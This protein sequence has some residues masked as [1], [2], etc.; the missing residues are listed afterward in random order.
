MLLSC[1]AALACGAFEPA[2][3][4][5]AQR[6][7]EHRIVVTVEK[8]TTSRAGSLDDFH[9]D[10]PWFEGSFAQA[11]ARA[12]TNGSGLLVDFWAEWCQPCRRMGAT[13]FRDERVI[14]DLCGLVCVSV[15]SQSAT[16]RVLAERYGVRKVP[17]LVW[18]EPDGTT[19]DVLIGYFGASEFLR[20]H[21]RIRSGQ[22]TFADLGRRVEADG[23][24]LDAR[25]K[26]A[27]K[28]QK[29]GDE[30][31]AAR[32]VRAIEALDREHK[33]LPMRL[34][35]L[36][37]VLART[38]QTF[39]A[40]THGYRLG[41][42]EQF[43]AGEAYSQVLFEGWFAHGRMQGVRVEALRREAA[44]VSEL[45]AAALAQLATYR[46]RVWPR[47]TPEREAYAANE[48]AWRHWENAEFLDADAKRFALQAAETAAEL[49]PDEPLILDTLACCTW[50]NGDRERART[51]VERCIELDPA[52]REWRLR[53]KAF[54]GE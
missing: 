4:G 27:R 26:L 1:I 40:E 48:I 42:L 14:A 18:L 32:H 29:L 15:D 44:P 13:T 16:G 50:M 31:G 9:G 51:L 22:D 2:Q 38:Y 12:R 37:A 54:A 25:W 46:E 11:Q 52:N 53:R 39:D 7:G 49:E 3:D 23:A 20:E 21:T 10:V 8:R 47:R 43:L 6:T 45:R 36:E 28:L 19:R 34:A 24:D 35:A 17:A 30:Q 5:S 41:E 33:S